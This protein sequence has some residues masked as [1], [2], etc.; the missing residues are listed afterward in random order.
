MAASSIRPRGAGMPGTPTSGCWAG[1]GSYVH[2]CDRG[3]CTVCGT[4]WPCPRT[5]RV[6]R[7]LLPANVVSHAA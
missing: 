5:E 1:A 6:Q 4:V 3:F 2:E 7:G